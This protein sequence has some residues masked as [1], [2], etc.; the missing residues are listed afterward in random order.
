MIYIYIYMIET[1]TLQVWVFC[2]RISVKLILV[3]HFQYD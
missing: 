1:L 3:V 2:A